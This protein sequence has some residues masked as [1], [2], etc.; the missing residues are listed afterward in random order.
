MSQLPTF[1]PLA[2]AADCARLEQRFRGKKVV[3]LWATTQPRQNVDVLLEL[4]GALQQEGIPV[5][6][7]LKEDAAA[8]VGAHARDRESFFLLNDAEPL[9]FLPCIDLL[10]TH[11]Y[12]AGYKK[13]PGFGGKVMY[14]NHTAAGHQGVAMDYFADYLVEINTNFSCDF[15]YA[16]IPAF[17]S[18]QHNP[19]LAL[20]PAGSIKLDLLASARQQA[21]ERPAPQGLLVS[22]YPLSSEH[23]LRGDTA[24]IRQAMG[25]W[26]TFVEGF[27]HT[28]PEGTFVFSPA[29]ADRTRD[30][31]LDFVET[32]RND[33]RFIFSEEDD[34][35]YWLARSDF[36]LTD[37]SSIDASWIFST[38]RPAIHLRPGSDETLHETAYGYTASCAA[39]ALQAL[40]DAQ[41]NLWRWKARLLK[42]R[43]EQF[44]FFGHSVARLC[45]AIRHIISADSPQPL[46][47]WGVLDKNVAAE[48]PALALLRFLSFR[49]RNPKALSMLHPAY[50]WQKVFQEMPGSGC[51][52]LAAL[53]EL[54]AYFS[55]VP[56]DALGAQTLLTYLE[57]ALERVPLRIL[58]QFLMNKLDAPTPELI[59]LL[60]IVL[61]HKDSAP[62][63]KEHF[64]EVLQKRHIDLQKF[65]GCFALP[66]SLGNP[67]F[68]PE[69]PG[70]IYRACTR[71]RPGEGGLPP[72]QS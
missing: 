64:I 9:R 71:S 10:V 38:L 24:K 22:F 33:G 2:T 32:W 63:Q 20:V 26:N 62:E 45:E 41:K 52:A 61:S 59:R 34:N 6:F 11:D 54:I 43:H 58:Y 29:V 19:Q 44:P 68:S 55:A 14:L 65:S 46:P 37:W 56:P 47:G 72:M 36:L 7:L 35:K 51:L 57:H 16:A 4:K 28:H 42:F 23:K 18:V 69:V 25:E 66:A 70:K 67:V 27:L 3:A 21:K 5:L 17:L 1:E 49:K 53:D 30:Y 8:F 50:V 13:I 60:C 15:D 12:V 31:I 39:D 48:K 40:A